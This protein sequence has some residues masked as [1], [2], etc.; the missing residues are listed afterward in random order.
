[1]ARVKR[2]VCLANSRKRSGRCIAGREWDG[3]KAG[4]WIRPVR[5]D[6]SK[7]ICVPCYAEGDRD[8]KVLDIVEVPLIEHRP[9]RHQ[10]EN[11]LF[12]PKLPWIRKGRVSETDLDAF[13]QYPD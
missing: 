10:Q 12:D 4:P 13:V 11:W 3:S 9:R 6:P 5:E 1:M 2:I 7:G 8:I